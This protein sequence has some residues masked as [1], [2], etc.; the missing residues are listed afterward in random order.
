MPVGLL[1]VVLEKYLLR[2]PAYFSVG[3]FGILLLFS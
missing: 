1:Y 2:S 3:L